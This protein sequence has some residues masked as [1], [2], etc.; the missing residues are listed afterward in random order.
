MAADTA[1]KAGR[2]PLLCTV[3]V[4]LVVLSTLALVDWTN[5]GVARPMWMLFLPLAFGIA[6][7]ISAWSK[8]SLA[9]VLLSAGL[10]FIALPALYF[11][12][13]LVGG[14]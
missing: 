10:G 14:P 11:T 2:V 7:A 1:V 3:M 13:T 8:N 12:T 4:A 5:S 6:G 9:G